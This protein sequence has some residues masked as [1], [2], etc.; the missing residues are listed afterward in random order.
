MGTG[1][2]FD[3]GVEEATD[4]L[5]TMLRDAV[6]IRTYADVPLGPFCPVASTRH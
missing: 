2:R 4:S 1:D 3:G 5:D 6:G